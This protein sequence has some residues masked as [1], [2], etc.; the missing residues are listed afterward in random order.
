MAFERFRLRLDQ[1]FYSVAFKQ[2]IKVVRAIWA[3]LLF[4]F[5]RGASS[6]VVDGLRGNFVSNAGVN[7]DS[8]NHDSLRDWFIGINICLWIRIFKSILALSFWL[9]FWFFHEASSTVVDGLLGNLI[10]WFLWWTSGAGL[11][12]FFL[13]A[14]L[15]KKEFLVKRVASL[16]FLRLGFL[17]LSV[18]Y[19]HIWI[20]L[21]SG[22]PIQ[23]QMSLT[24]LKE[25]RFNSIV[26]VVKVLSDV[27]WLAYGFQAL[28][29]DEFATWCFIHTFCINLLASRRFNFSSGLLRLDMCSF[30][31]KLVLCKFLR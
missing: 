4:W 14:L 3:G 31:T 26:S 12:I 1:L 7:H 16:S 11:T 6:T 8:V 17:G 18:L 19:F 30:L 22:V 28:T 24:L 5:L 27:P 13:L 9:G 25:I 21:C 10:I 20:L 29:A 2:N 15:I 23:I